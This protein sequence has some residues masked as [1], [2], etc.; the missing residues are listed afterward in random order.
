M[1]CTPL[2]GVLTIHF[3]VV[4]LAS[5]WCVVAVVTVR[6]FGRD[7]RHV[8]VGAH[9]GVQVD[10]DANSLGSHDADPL[11]VGYAC[12]KAQCKSRYISILE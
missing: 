7:C 3:A 11:Y 5:D 12:C 9:V 6:L 10:S 2:C 8:V 1:L 4:L